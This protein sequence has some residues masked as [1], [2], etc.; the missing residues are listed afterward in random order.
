ML[1][2]I[3]FFIPKT[4]EKTLYALP[5]I[6]GVFSLKQIEA[7]ALDV[8]CPIPFS[9]IRSFFVFGKLPPNF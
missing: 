4:L 9:F 7:I 1:E 2:E 6:A 8:Y 3:S 5:S